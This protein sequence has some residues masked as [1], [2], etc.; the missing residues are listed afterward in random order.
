MEYKNYICRECI[1]LIHMG[2]NFFSPLK[3]PL[4]KDVL[5]LCMMIIDGFLAIGI[6][7]VCTSTPIIV[8]LSLLVFFA[9]ILAYCCIKNYITNNLN[10]KRKR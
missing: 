4:Q 7:F 10:K 3:K 9:S 1:I 6:T 8:I 2:K 5:L